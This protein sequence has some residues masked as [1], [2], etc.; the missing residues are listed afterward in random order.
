MNDIQ[1]QLTTLRDKG[2]TVA[3]IADELDVR[4]M[5]VHRWLSGTRY[6]EN[7]KGVRSLLDELSSRK[8]IPKQRRYAGTH[9]LQRKADDD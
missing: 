2:W 9:H 5:T 1:E 4:S 7:V 6:P 8:R 3:A